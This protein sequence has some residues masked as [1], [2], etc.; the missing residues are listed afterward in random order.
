MEILK[1]AYILTYI[2]IMYIL[3]EFPSPAQL[4]ILD[5][6]KSLMYKNTYSQHSQTDRPFVPFFPDFS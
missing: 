2:S 4:I 3:P 6:V 1:R 5:T